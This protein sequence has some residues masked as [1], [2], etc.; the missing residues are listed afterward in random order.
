M[1]QFTMNIDPGLL[2]AAKRH[3][4][5]NEITMSDL[6]RDLL[7]RE[8]GWTSARPD[9]QLD[10]GAALPV[11]QEY[12]VGRLTRRQAMDALGLAPERQPEFVAAMN[13][14]SVPWPSPD[15]VQ[16]ELEAEL[17]ADAIREAEGE[18]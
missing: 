18:D 4:L 16:I 10:H 2:H 14:H 17:V 12:S 3:A 8:V 13:R 7:A 15:P 5:A 1:R 11:L 6:V 9:P